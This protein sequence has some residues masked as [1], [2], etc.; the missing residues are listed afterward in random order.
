MQL[1]TVLFSQTLYLGEYDNQ[2]VAK[3]TAIKGIYFYAGKLFPCFLKKSRLKWISLQT[4][5]RVVESTISFFPVSR[6]L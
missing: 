6:I 3:V 4:L 2:D 1:L 5:I